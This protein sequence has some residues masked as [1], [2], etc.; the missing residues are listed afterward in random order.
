MFAALVTITVFS[1]VAQQSPSSPLQMADAVAVSGEAELSAAE[2]Y[3]SASRAAEDHLRRRWQHRVDRAVAERRPFW[4]PAILVEDR[5]QRW[6][7]DLPMSRLTR[8]VDRHDKERIH[9]FGNSYQTTLWVAEE[10]RFVETGAARLRDELRRLERATAIRYGC[11][12]AGW[13]ILAL[14]IGWID[15]LSRG[16]MTG[17]L[18]LLGLT[19]GVVF[20]VIAFL[21]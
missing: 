10:P 15:R 11:I 21:V 7:L 20:P 13:A 17:R 1:A 12:V 2:A 16:Y 14:V 19:C 18:R 4:L 5:V 8:I 3:A 9:E 6:L